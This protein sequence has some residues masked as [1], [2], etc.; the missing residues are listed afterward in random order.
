MI[1]DLLVVDASA[2]S[3]NLG[4]DNYAAGA[5]PAY[6]RCVYQNFVDYKASAI[7]GQDAVYDNFFELTGR[8]PTTWAE[9][10]KTH[11]AAFKQ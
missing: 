11:A 4:E 5:D 3:S 10:A 7:P 9:F 1:Q 8:K 2:H 6:M